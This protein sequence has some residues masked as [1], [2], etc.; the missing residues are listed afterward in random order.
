MR[1]D[2]VEVVISFEPEESYVYPNVP[3]CTCDR[4]DDEDEA[5][6]VFCAYHE[7]RLRHLRWD[8]LACIVID[9]EAVLHANADRLVPT[10]QCEGCD[11]WFL[12]TR[13]CSVRCRYRIAKRRQR[14]RAKAAR[15]DADWQMTVATA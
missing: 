9:Y 4:D 3:E 14:E 11:T 1:P 13:F 12:R 10:G 6:R 15:M 8:T 2:F 7:D 5:P